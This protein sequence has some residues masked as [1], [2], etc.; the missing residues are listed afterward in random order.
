MVVPLATSR[1]RLQV[2]PSSQQRPFALFRVQNV[3][4]RAGASTPACPEHPELAVKLARIT[5]TLALC[6]V[7][8]NASAQDIFGSIVRRAAETAGARLVERAVDGVV[9]ATTRDAPPS[10]AAPDR[11][12]RATPQAPASDPALDRL[13]EEERM[14]ECNRRVPL[15]PDGGRS[16]EKQ[17]A[18]VSCMGPR[19]GDGG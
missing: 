15:D 12:G 1:I 7:A 17:Q 3:C 13:S 18:F 8:G 11:R 14:A 2:E 19:F 6:A 10:D 16:Y 5:L 9:N 4:R